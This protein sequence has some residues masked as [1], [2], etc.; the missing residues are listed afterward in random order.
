MLR[1]RAQRAN[2]AAERARYAAL[3]AAKLARRRG[4][5]IPPFLLGYGDTPAGG[6]DDGDSAAGSRGSRPRRGRS[7]GE[8]PRGERRHH[9]E[10]SRR[11]EEAR[12]PPSPPLELAEEAPA[13]V[14]QPRR[15]FLARLLRRAPTPPPAPSIDDEEAALVLVVAPRRPRR[16]R[17]GPRPQEERSR[18]APMMPSYDDEQLWPQ[19]EEDAMPRFAAPRGQPRFGPQY[20]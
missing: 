11:S 12:R 2:E 5:P 3:L 13:P 20:V 15:G 4:V 9:R 1:R 7:H 16:R 19:T 14:Q 6:G 10:R 17:S 8:R 18:G